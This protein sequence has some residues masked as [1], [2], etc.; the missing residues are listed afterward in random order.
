[1]HYL[2]G[3]GTQPHV[4]NA[5]LEVL[6]QGFIDRL[7]DSLILDPA[8]AETARA[9][10]HRGEFDRIVR[11]LAPVAAKHEGDT[12]NE[13][14]K[15]M[16][17]KAAALSR[18]HDALGNVGA[19]GVVYTQPRFSPFQMLQGTGEARPSHPQRR[20]RRCPP[21]CKGSLRR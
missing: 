4:R 2:R 18:T 3:R 10:Y 19:C 14:T 8:D 6:V 21:S 15:V 20:I 7:Y 1:M 17:V 16:Y 12:W 13:Y 11:A 5:A 9:A